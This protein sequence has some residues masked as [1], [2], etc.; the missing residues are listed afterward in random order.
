MENKNKIELINDCC[1]VFD[2]ERWNDKIFNW[3]KKPF[4]MVTVPA[5]NHVPDQSKLQEAIISM[6]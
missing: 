4:I 5:V 6:M 1:P 3:N 2:P